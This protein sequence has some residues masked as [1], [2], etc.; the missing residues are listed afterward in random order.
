MTFA[1]IVRT[2]ALPV[3]DWLDPAELARD[4]YPSFRRL[5]EEAPVAW[6]PAVN[7]VLISSYEGC[8]FGERHPEIFSSNVS[9]GTMVRAMGG[10][11]MI[12]KDDPEHAA[13][14]APMNRTLRPKQ[15]MEIWAGKFE[16]NARH[17]LEEMIEA[18]PGSADLNLDFA[19]PLAAKNLCDML[20]MTNVE[21]LDLARWSRDFIAGTGNVLDKQEIWDR[22]ETSRAECDAA[23]DET[24]ARLR[25]HPDPSITSM[26]IEAGMDEDKVRN[27]VKL[28]ISGGVNEP[29]HMITNLVWLLDRS[30][31]QKA[32]LWADPGLWKQ[33]FIEASRYFSPIGM[34]TR[35]TVADVVIG[36]VTI[37]ADTQIGMIL[38]SANRDEK[39]FPNPDVFDI[40]RDGGPNLAFGSGVHQCAG[41]WAAQKAVGEIAVPMLYRE[42]PELR[43]DA[44]RRE[45]WDGWVF[46]GMTNLPVVW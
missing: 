41:K 32:E 7:K 3:A 21:P 36:D 10:Q 40:H 26:L 37:P 6:V 25:R 24:M 19:K 42:L 11:P 27:N 1:T 13:E 17:Y 46:R 39:Q 15:I 2:K 43:Q 12:R 5:R 16:A 14:R 34:I 29:Q 28:A 20:G 23:L 44:G 4:P 30:P 8:S 9:G 38:A 18:G 45:T 35:E 33:A 31:E 22:C